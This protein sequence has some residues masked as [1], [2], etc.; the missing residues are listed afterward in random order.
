MADPGGGITR[1]CRHP[2]TVSYGYKNEFLRPF[3]HKDMHIDFKAAP[4]NATKNVSAVLR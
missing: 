4:R 1:I 2:I 3:T